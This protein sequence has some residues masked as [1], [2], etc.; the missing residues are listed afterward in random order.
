[1]S[2][3]WPKIMKD[4]TIEELYNIANGQSTLD[5]EAEK[6]AEKELNNRNFFLD[7]PTKINAKIELEKLIKEQ[8]DEKS[9]KR[10]LSR[11]GKIDFQFQLI[12][13]IV[14]C[15]G[16]LIA[17][18]NDYSKPGRNEILLLVIISIIF[19][20]YGYIQYKNAKRRELYRKKRIKEL[21]NKL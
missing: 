3:D 7:K 19:T 11:F 5:L 17:L 6:L 1:M 18:Y 10:F 12:T 4:K 9:K 14:M 13:G 16:S 20:T 2:Y 15:I 8:E 21:R